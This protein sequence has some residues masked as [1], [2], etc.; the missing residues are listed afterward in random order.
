MNVLEA[1]KKAFNIADVIDIL[2][3]NIPLTEL[4]SMYE[5]MMIPSNKP[6]ERSY[7][8]KMFLRTRM[9]P[10]FKLLFNVLHKVFLSQ[11]GTNEQ[12]TFYK[13]RLMVAVYKNLNVNWTRIVLF[14][15]KEEM[16]KIMRNLDD[17]GLLK[18]LVVKSKLNLC[19]NIS[20]L[21][22]TN[23]QRAD[24]IG[25]EEFDTTKC[26]PKDVR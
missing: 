20:L 23:V 15:I 13:F 10:T 14:N 7:Q 2:L 25:S 3:D 5:E 8:L 21:I 22:L 16:E 24:W 18:E 4:Q 12:V 26:I 11:T 19:S 6:E 1:I 17:K 9:K